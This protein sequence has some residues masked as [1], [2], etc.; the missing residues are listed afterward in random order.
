[1]VVKKAVIL[2]AFLQCWLIISCAST[3]RILTNQYD[4]PLDIDQQALLYVPVQFKVFECD[5]EK[6]ENAWSSKKDPFFGNVTPFIAVLPPGEHLLKANYISQ[7]QSGGYQYTSTAKDLLL[8]YDFIAGH[9]YELTL[10]FVIIEPESYK[11][12][13]RLNVI[14][15]TT[16]PGENWLNWLD[17]LRNK[18]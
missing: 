11:F 17:A 6:V 5:N 10:D 7:T 4:K 14:D 3:N 2:W 13:V 8:S 16:N 1:M 18:K 9:I 12:G 15:K